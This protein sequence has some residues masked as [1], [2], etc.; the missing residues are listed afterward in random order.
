MCPF[1]LLPTFYP[2][3][4][5]STFTV[6][7]CAPK[8]NRWNSILANF[9]FHKMT[10]VMK[11]NFPIVAVFPS[12]HHPRHKQHQP[13]TTGNATHTHTQ[14]LLG[15]G[16]DEERKDDANFYPRLLFLRPTTLRGNEISFT[17]NYFISEIIRSF[18]PG[19]SCS[20]LADITLRRDV[21][22]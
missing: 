22:G 1:E 19:S 20:L 13:S 14:L 9:N 18:P 8:N 6:V 2:D 10:P 11:L 17:G 21:E 4:L 5:S 15:K 16:D 7:G 12:I 3:L